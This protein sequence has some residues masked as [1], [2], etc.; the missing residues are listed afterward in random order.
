MIYCR[1]LT[2]ALFL[3]GWS[4]GCGMAE[5]L[6]PPAIRVPRAETA[7]QVTAT[8]DDP[9]WAGAAKVERLSETVGNAEAAGHG[10]EV[11]VQLL[12]TP[13][14]LF[15]RFRS[16]QDVPFFT[17]FRDRRDAEHYRGD[18][19]EVFLDPI[20]DARQMIEI[21]LNPEGGVFDLLGLATA[22]PEWDAD[23]TFRPE[24]WTR[25]WWM[26]REWNVP[27]LRTASRTDRE[28][29][30]FVWIADL[31][32]PAK[33]LLQRLGGEDLHPMRLRAN[34]LRYAG[35]VE[36]GERH[37]LLSYNWAPVRFGQPHLSPP[38]YGTLELVEP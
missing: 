13:E 37:L 17:P 1:F 4:A 33:V 36:N 9:A 14:A 5:S 10:A 25:N 27:G 22:E 8:A 24:F 21:Q 29:G 31:A 32:I 11:S 34:F 7:P 30:R 16:V 28:N 18:V 2:G 15:I 3:W 23:G 26:L 12:W 38:A 35:P 20:G 6:P 19:V